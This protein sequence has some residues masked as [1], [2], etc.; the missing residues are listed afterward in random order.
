MTN[1]T[2]IATALCRS[3]SH[4]TAVT[5]DNTVFGSLEKISDH[6]FEKISGVNKITFKRI[7]ESSGKDWIKAFKENYLRSKKEEDRRISLMYGL[8]GKE[9]IK[10]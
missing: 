1:Q 6:Q 2:Q 8:G 3:A 9:E 7:I 10:K 5:K 4:I